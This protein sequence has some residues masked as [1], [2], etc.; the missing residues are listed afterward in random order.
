MENI[1][2]GTGLPLRHPDHHAAEDPHAPLLPAGGGAA[3]QPPVL[4]K[5]FFVEGLMISG[6]ETPEGL[7]MDSGDA[8]EVMAAV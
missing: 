7:G 5:N 6:E 3:L 8:I 4:P 2:Q 1:G